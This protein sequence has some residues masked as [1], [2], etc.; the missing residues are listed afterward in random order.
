MKKPTEQILAS[1]LALIPGCTDTLLKQIGMPL[2]EVQKLDP[3][4]VAHVE[5]AA[6]SGAHLIAIGRYLDAEQERRAAFER[7]IAERVSDLER[8]LGMRPA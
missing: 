2:E 6:R 5:S 7:A 3:L 8:E 4:L 1:L